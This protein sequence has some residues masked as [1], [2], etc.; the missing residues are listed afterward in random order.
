MRM[1]LLYKSQDVMKV[2][3]GDDDLPLGWRKKK[4]GRRRDGALYI[5]R[6]P[7]HGLVRVTMF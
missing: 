6:R 2:E 7:A 1:P 4:R 5:G 3:G